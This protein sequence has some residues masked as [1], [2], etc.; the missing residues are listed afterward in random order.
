MSVTARCTRH[1]PRCAAS[2]TATKDAR[3][4]ADFEKWE[5]NPDLAAAY[6]A[7]DAGEVQ[8]PEP[9]FRR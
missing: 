3:A 8:V 7:L 2:T 5:L 1:D 4:W 9:T 6:A